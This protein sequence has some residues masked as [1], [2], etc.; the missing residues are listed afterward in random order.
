MYVVTEKASETRAPALFLLRQL[1][2]G[3]SI[4]GKREKITKLQESGM[5]EK[6]EKIKYKLG[7]FGVF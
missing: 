7:I 5:D 2:D 3:V 1:R 6:F 4:F